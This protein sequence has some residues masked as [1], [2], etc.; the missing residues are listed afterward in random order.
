[1]RRFT[2]VALLV[3][4]AAT[5]DAADFVINSTGDRGDSFPGD[6]VCND[7]TGA[8]TLRAAIEESNA[9][10]G[11]DNLT[12]DLPSP[13]YI[14]P[15]SPLPDLSEHSGIIIN[16][17]TQPGY[18]GTPVVQIDGSELGA[19]DGLRSTAG[20]AVITGLCIHSF[21]GNGIVLRGSHFST[22]QGNY[23]GTDVTGT[24]AR[25]N[26]LYGVF[27]LESTGNDIGGTLPGQGDLISGNGDGVFVSA[28]DNIVH[29]NLIGTDASG[30]LP[31]GNIL[32]GV[33]VDGRKNI[34]GGTIPAAA[35]TIAASGL[36]GVVLEPGASDNRIIG[37]R[38][39]TDVSGTLALPN[40]Q[41]VL[42]DEAPGRAP[43]NTIG[44]PGAGNLIAG[45]LSA[46]VVVSGA[47]ADGNLIQGNTVGLA[48]D[49]VSALP[50]LGDGVVF[51]SGAANTLFGGTGTGE[52]NTV[53]YNGGAGVLVESGTGHRL[54]G[55]AIY[56]NDGLGI[57]L[58][59]DAAPTANDPGDV[60]AGANQLQ[61]YPELAAA[62]SSCT[63]TTIDG[64][65]AREPNRT[66]TVEFFVTAACDP[67]GHGEGE[68]YLGSHTV[69]TDPS[70][71]AGFSAVVPVRV[72]SG[73]LLTAT[74]AD[75]QGNTSEFSLCLTPT[76]DCD[77]CGN[78]V[79]DPGE[80]CDSGGVDTDM[81]D[82]DCTEVMCGDDHLNMAAGE[83]C[84]DGNLMDG[85]GCSS[86]CRIES[87][88][89]GD[90][91]AVTR[92]KAT[93][94]GGGV[95]FTWNADP[96]A[97]E[98]HVNSVTGKVELGDPHRDT[99]YGFGECDATATSCID[100]DGLA[101]AMPDLYYQVLSACGPS[102][103][104]EGPF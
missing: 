75:D 104:D 70:G 26:S 32:R 3:S 19:A 22:I 33:V 2:F 27:I 86:A 85:D 44:E 94:G 92:L 62:T 34:I 50:N 87:C 17:T 101:A 78:L 1:M 53:A 65:L 73:E 43:P 42:V 51:E 30:T 4:V 38:I 98:Y 102:G 31:L 59:S 74:A 89:V 46:G 64:T 95:A 103:A 18:S 82:A 13:P 20:H 58:G 76:V 66:Y 36:Y 61:N 21:R 49:G 45:N 90:L 47:D 71:T 68:R 60:D 28:E 7:G 56:D 67:S 84:D 11:I 80:F 16:G 24:V 14:L 69:T 25:P 79:Q 37:N 15:L 57:D 72:L 48:A 5:A 40:L 23:I 55:N 77:L 99:G 93:K 83:E 39:G 100:L 9:R 35:N 97:S 41:G 29:G 12:F 8:C 10:F 52:G 96:A 54:S 81:C 91:Q 6:Q 88:L 63:D